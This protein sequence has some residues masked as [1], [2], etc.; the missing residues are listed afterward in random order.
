MGAIKISLITV[1]FNAGATIEHCIQSVISQTYKNVEY[2]IVDG[3]STDA[4]CQI[5][6]KYGSEINH[7]VSEPDRGIY[8]AMNKGINFATGD[9][10]GM[11][12]ADDYFSDSSVLAN[13]AAVFEDKTVGI[14]Y[15]DLDFVNR[16]GNIFRKWRS[17]RY[18]PG[19]FNWG[20]MPPHP[21]FYC[22][23][24]LFNKYG[25]YSL[26]YGTAG[27]YELMLRFMHKHGLNSFYLKK[28]II[29]MKSGG[30][31]NKTLG[32]R[33]K[34]FIDDFRAMRHNGIRSPFAAVLL[35]RLRKIDQY[36]I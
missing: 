20:W 12:N 18:T 14:L 5:V 33:V 22:R 32:S 23:R 19:K 11:L 21:T 3:G 34:G 6:N 8:D 29:K 2:I 27:D 35:K 30:A 10:V 26:N 16:L 9:I 36:I 4:T 1:T 28:T 7:F 13:I 31:S 25:C 24:E 17:G 15:G